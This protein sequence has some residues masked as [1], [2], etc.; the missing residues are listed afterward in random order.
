MSGHFKASF[1]GSIGSELMQKTRTKKS[2]AWALKML[3][4]HICSTVLLLGPPVFTCSIMLAV[5]LDP[6]PVGQ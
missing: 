6:A 3:G 1:F 4:W 2:H 5:A